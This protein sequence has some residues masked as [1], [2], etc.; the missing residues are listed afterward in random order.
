MMIRLALA[1]LICATPLLAQSPATGTLS[2]NP[3]YQ[4]NCAKCHGKTAQGRHFAGPSLVSAKASGMSID[5]LRNIITHGKHRM[6]KFEAKLSKQ[7][8]DDLV[9]EIKRKNR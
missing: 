4:Q 9:S 5:D 6:P 2:S 1:S 7:Q 8:V 3:V